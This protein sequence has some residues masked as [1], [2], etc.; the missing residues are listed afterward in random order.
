MCTSLQ[1]HHA[2]PQLS[3]INKKLE[4]IM[5]RLNA[6]SAAQ[7]PVNPSKA[8]TPTTGAKCPASTQACPGLRFEL[9]LAQADRSHHALSDLSNDGLLEKV[10]EAL[11]DVHCHFESRPCTPD[12]EG[13]AGSEYTM[14]CIC[15]VGHHH[16]GDIWMV[17]YSEAEHNFLT[18]TAHHWVPWLSN[19]L[20][21]THK[22]SPV[23][24]HGMPTSFNPS[25]D[26][27]NICHLVVQNNHLITHPSML[28]HTEFLL[29]PHT[30][31][32]CKTRGSLILYLTHA[33]A[34]NDCI[35]HHVAYQGHLLPTVK[36]TRQPPQCY[37]CHLFSHFAR[38]CR[39]TAACGCCTGMHATRV[40]KCP[41]AMECATP[42]PCR[43]IQPKCAAYGGPHPAS[44]MDCPARVA[45]YDHQRSRLVD[46][47]PF[48]MLSDWCHSPI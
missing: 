29:R 30:A 36:F 46:T 17:M 20:T 39:A 31:S 4:T 43:H 18:G 32:Q 13:N 24:V 47:G 3:D 27:N 23:L 44:H 25:R 41:E 1:G 12:H 37:N 6:L 34:A 42:T 48:Y 15:A 33:K 16:S 14:P 35:A 19:Q 28:Q 21:V 40:C 10:N 22:T 9:T 11:M 2:N 7:P 26:S 8:H 38:S 45:A 5:T